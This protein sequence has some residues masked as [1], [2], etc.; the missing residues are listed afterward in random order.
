MIANKM[1]KNNYDMLP[2]SGCN[3]EENKLVVMPSDDIVR[4]IFIGR[5]MKLKG[6]DEYLEAAKTVKAKYPNTEFIIAGW[7]EEEEYVKTVADY[8][9]AEIV[10]YIGFRKDIKDLIASS[11]CTVLPSH[12]GEGVPNVLLE[13]AAA[14]RIC[15][16][17][18]I[19]GS[20]DVIE[21][22][23]TGYLFDT[24]DAK[25]LA[26][27][28]EKVIALSYEQKTE[29]GLAGRAKVEREFDRQIVVEKYMEEVAGK[30]GVTV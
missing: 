25:S 21:D 23:K 11:H 13:S 24:H 16:A 15:I 22:G 26:D 2:G 20:M 9:E 10:N 1:V 29:M 8:Q 14:G 4:F 30:Q 12:G 18:K 7:N 6:I 28:M 17:S 27:S 3:L 5:V 19:N